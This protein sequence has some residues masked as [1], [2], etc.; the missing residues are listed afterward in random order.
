VLCFCMTRLV[1][2]FFIVFTDKA[3][4]QIMATILAI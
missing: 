3:W 1:V 2:A 4:L